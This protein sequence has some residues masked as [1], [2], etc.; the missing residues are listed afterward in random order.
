MGVAYTRDHTLMGG[1]SGKTEAEV[2]KQEIRGGE[3]D[4]VWL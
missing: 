3:V 4:I 1:A 2:S